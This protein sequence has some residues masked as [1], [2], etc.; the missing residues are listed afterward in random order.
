M[1]ILCLAS[2]R[3][4]CALAGLSL[5]PGSNPIAVVAAGISYMVV[6]ASLLTGTHLSVGLIRCLACPDRTAFAVSI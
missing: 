3:R 2:V 6:P 4:G 5:S 1:V